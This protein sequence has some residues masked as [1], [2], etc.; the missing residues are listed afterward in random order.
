MSNKRV[1]GYPGAG[2][3]VTVGKADNIFELIKNY[4]DENDTESTIVDNLKI[5][6]LT[7]VTKQPTSI[8]I[9]NWL[10]IK[11][12]PYDSNSGLYFISIDDVSIQGKHGKIEVM[13]DGIEIDTISFYYA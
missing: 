2:S 13:D 12:M 6:G 4:M 7:I 8:S 11:L 10:P 3:T 9:N 1:A 5:T